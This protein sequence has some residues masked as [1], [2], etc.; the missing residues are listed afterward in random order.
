MVEKIKHAHETGNNH[1]DSR[2]H[3]ERLQRHYESLAEASS[4]EHKDKLDHIINKIE[5]TAKTGAELNSHHQPVEKPSLDDHRFVGSQLKD[6]H[7]KRSLKKI[8]K[9]LKPYQRPLSRFMHIGFVE[10]T[11]ELVE[12]TIARPNGLLLGGLISFIASLAIL[13]I[14]RYY[15][16][17]YNFFI[18]LIS[19][20][21]GLILGSIGELLLKP[22]KHR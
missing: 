4:H 10:S 16:Y 15:G 19:F 6:N 14:C 2:E 13:I 17:E 12:K 5:A 8:Q 21:V 3:H 1:E 18:G 22:V 20:P 9:E 7:L 11:S